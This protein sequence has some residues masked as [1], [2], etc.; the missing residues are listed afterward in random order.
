[1][2]KADENQFCRI[3]RLCCPESGVLFVMSMLMTMCTAMAVGPAFGHEGCGELSHRCAKLF[4]HCLQHYIL[5]DQNMVI[6]NLAGRMAVADMPGDARQIFMPHREQRFS[7]RLNDNDAPII[8]AKPLA[9]IDRP[10]LGKLNQ[11]RLAAIAN[12]P[13]APQESCLVIKRYCVQCP[14]VWIGAGMN[15]RLNSGSV[16]VLLS[17]TLFLE[18]RPNRSP[19]NVLSMETSLGAQNPTEDPQ[20]RRKVR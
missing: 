7:R 10:C 13:L 8:K 20:M 6:G 11:K 19:N 5:A 16:I 12:Q 14:C 9:M 15:M 1:M 18:I 4:Q 2:G 3:N 17:W